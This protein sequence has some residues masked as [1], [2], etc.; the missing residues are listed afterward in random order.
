LY[1]FSKHY[2]LI[3]HLIINLP[4]KTLDK[5]GKNI[6]IQGDSREVKYLEDANEKPNKEVDLNSN[7]NDLIDGAQP[8]DVISLV[9]GKI[10]TYII[11]K[12]IN[13]EDFMLLFDSVEERVKYSKFR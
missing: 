12:K 6:H 8:K 3:N 1:S 11:N 10:K 7:F 9:F 4:N 13:L 2:L 5:I